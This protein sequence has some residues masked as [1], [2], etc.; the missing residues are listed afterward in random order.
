MCGLFTGRESI[1][2]FLAPSSPHCVCVLT[3]MAQTPH[4]C[5]LFPP[6]RRAGREQRPD[7]SRLPLDDHS[8]APQARPQHPGERR[9]HRGLHVPGKQKGGLD[10]RPQRKRPFLELEAAFVHN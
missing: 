10:F 6:Q 2:L 9:P 8:G 5:P 3:T 4:I 7:L 1:C